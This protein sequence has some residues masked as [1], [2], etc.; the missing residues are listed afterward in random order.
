M[1]ALRDIRGRRLDAR[2]FHEVETVR[3]G[4]LPHLQGQRLSKVVQR[5]PDL[6]FPAARPSFRAAADRRAGVSL[7]APGVFAGRSRHR[8]EPWLSIWG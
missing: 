5:R 1:A 4:L 8:R 3:R 7:R 2:N 6:R